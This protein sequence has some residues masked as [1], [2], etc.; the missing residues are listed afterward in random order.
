M[1]KKE[2]AIGIKILS[3]TITSVSL[4]G[5]L[6][7]IYSY[8]FSMMRFNHVIALILVVLLLISSIIFMS[9]KNLLEWNQKY[10][11]FQWIGELITLPA[12][13]LG[14]LYNSTHVW[15]SILFLS[16]FGGGSILFIFVKYVRRRSRNKDKTKL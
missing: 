11:F 10:G 2:K 1:S 14:S 9:A 15:Y 12:F 3:W 7:D 13:F 16:L 5:F 8:G 4:I 6:G